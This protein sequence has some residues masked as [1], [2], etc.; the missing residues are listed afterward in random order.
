VFFAD[1]YD[2]IGTIG[3]KAQGEG[4]ITPVAP[5]IANALADATGVRFAHLRSHRTA[6]STSSA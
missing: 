2:A 5:A 4:S 3:A 1:T 6:S